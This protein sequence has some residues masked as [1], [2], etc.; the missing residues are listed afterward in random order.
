MRSI[1]GRRQRLEQHDVVEPVEELRPEVG[2][3][4][5]HHRLAGAL[6]ELAAGRRSPRPG[7]RE[8]MFEV[9]ITTV[10]LKSTVRPCA[11][12]RR[13]SSSSCRSTLKT[14][15]CAF[16]ISSKRI[17]RVGLAP[18]RLG[19]L[20]ALLVADVA[21]AERRSAATPC[22]SPCTPTCR[23][24]PGCPRCRRAPAASALA[25]SV[26]PTPV[27]P[28]KRNEPIGRRG[29]LMPER[30]RS[31]ASATA[32]TASSWPITRR[33]RISSSRS[34]FSR[35]P[36]TSRVTGMPVQRETISAI[37]CLGD[38]LAQQPR[39]AAAAPAPPAIDVS[40]AFS[41]PSSEGIRPCRSSA[42]RFRS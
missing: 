40:A 5:A 29:S 4:L 42:A 28:R 27:G 7:A 11:S 19:E 12:V 25:S 1:S 22:A 26:L 13:P 2:A 34:S 31:T 39:A 33:C 6:G 20:A 23:C 38:L 9:R 10:F 36:S 15:W 18:H 37:S 21:R 3:Q 30:A 32:A 24:A 14:S 16:S 35:S 17:T 8:P 41:L